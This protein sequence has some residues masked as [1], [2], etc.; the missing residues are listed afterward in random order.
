MNKVYNQLSKEELI[1]KLKKLESR[2]KYGLI[3]DE[4]KTK[5]QFE[6]DAQNS[7]PVLK[8]LKNKEIKKEES[9]L[10]NILIEGDNY[11]AL[12]VLNFTHQNKIDVIYIDP[13]YN[14]GSKDFKYNDRYIEKEDSYRHSQWLSFMNK[15]LRLAKKLLKNEGVLFISIDDNEYARLL[16]LLEDIF[17]EDKLKTVCV[18]MAEPTGVKMAHVITN[19]GLP[20]LKEYLIIAKKDGIK[21]IFID[22]IPKDK[23]DDE[24]KTIIGAV[25]AKLSP[26]AKLIGGAQISEDMAKAIRVLLIVTGVKSSQILGHGESLDTLRHSEIENELGIEFFE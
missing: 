17:S 8:E 19:G 12:S 6:K 25:G 13:P 26:D 20:K 24:Y 15:R 22:K 10:T 16:L 18:K 1:E 21:N 3:W 5:E 14:T 4:E 23:W 9:K 2:K 7:L 11:H